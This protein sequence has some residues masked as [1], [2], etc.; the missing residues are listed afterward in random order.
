MPLR[1]LRRLAALLPAL[2]LLAGAL[3]AAAA[4][5]ATPADG[6]GLPAMPL[7]VAATSFDPT[8]RHSIDD[9]T[10][11]VGGRQLQAPF[12]SL[13]R[14]TG[15]LARWGH[16]TSEVLSEQPGALCQYFQRGV[17]DFRPRPDGG[18]ALAPRPVWDALRGGGIAAEPPPPDAGADAVGRWG[19]TLRDTLPDG[20]AIGFAAAFRRLGG[21][22]SL[23]EPETEARPDTPAPGRM[24]LPGGAD[25]VIRQYFQDAVLEYHPGSAEPVQ[26]PL[27]GDALRDRRYPGG[28]WRTLD[29][30][31]PQTPLAEGELLGLGGPAAAPGP[32]PPRLAV[33]VTPPEVVQGESFTLRV[34]GPPGLALSATLDGMSLPGTVGSVTLPLAPAEGGGYWT[35]GGFGPIQDPGTARLRLTARDGAGAAVQQAEV[36]IPVLPGTY[37]T[38]LD[39]QQIAI[40]PDKQALDDPALQRRENA[41]LATIFDRFTPRQL[42]QGRFIYPATGFVLTTGFGERRIVAGQPGLRYHEGLDL[43]LPQGTPF[44]AAADGV[45]V[46]AR[47][48]AVRGNMT[49]IDHGMGVYSA[50]LHQVRFGV[51]EGQVVHQG[52]VIGYVGSTGYSTGPH[53]H[54]ELRVDDVYVDPDQWT[55]QDFGP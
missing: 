30:F 19:H 9:L 32:T 21:A 13:Y 50:Y 54:W 4:E 45:V 24:H 28:R 39:A 25:G 34:N 31:R 43:A 8:L 2:L 36:A 46:M 3:P 40:P 29:A 52:E 51:T 26:L 18:Y 22:A 15:G 20:T 55:R 14:Q 44:V 47:P 7:R 48:M 53:L 23:G 17:L 38:Y 5:V 12:L 35:I 16:P 33:T 49:I 6:G 1:P 10:V 37:A 11:T 41:F 42:W 27:L